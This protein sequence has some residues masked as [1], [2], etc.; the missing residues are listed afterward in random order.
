[1]T[2]KAAVPWPLKFGLKA[3]IGLCRIDYRLLKRSGIVEFGRMEDVDFSRDVFRRHVQT[4]YVSLSLLVPAGTLLELGPGDS[5]TTGFIARSAGFAKVILIDAGDFA[6]LRPASLTALRASLASAGIIVP[7][8]AGPDVPH[9]LEMLGI[10]YLTQGT[11]SL[12]TLEPGGLS[13][14]FSNAVLQHVFRD[15]LAELMQC[16]GRAHAPGTLS[17]HSI[18]FTDTFSG[19]FVNHRLPEWLMESQLVKR[20]NLYTNRVSLTRY[21][22]L[23]LSADF[24][25]RRATVEFRDADAVAVDYHSA[26]DLIRAAESRQAQR[27]FVLLQKC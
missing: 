16:L 7:E 14:S 12:R 4:P 5:V 6:D 25:V 13:H 8:I 23:F 22:E 1:L 20:G 2:V 15:E 19:G 9:D 18:D 26:H 21:C 27:A 11:A 3:L 17:A 24:T 10:Q